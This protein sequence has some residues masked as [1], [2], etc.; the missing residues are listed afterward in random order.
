MG[1]SVQSDVLKQNVGIL[2]NVKTMNV[3][4]HKI[5]IANH[6]T[7]WNGDKEAKTVNIIV[8]TEIVDDNCRVTMISKNPKIAAGQKPYASDIYELIKDD[9]KTKNLIFASGDIVSADGANIWKGVVKRGRHISVY[10]TSKNQYVLTPVTTE[11]DLEKYIDQTYDKSKY[12]FVLSETLEEARSTITTFAIMEIKR[13]A[14]WPL[15]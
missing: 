10:D 6:V 14:S 2:G 8:D 3:C 9:V 13:K 5:A 15:F 4:I 11:K 1:V 12:I 7:Y